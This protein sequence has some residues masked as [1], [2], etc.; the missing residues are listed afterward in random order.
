MD[1]HSRHSEAEAGC[2]LDEPHGL[3]ETHGLPHLHER[4]DLD[5]LVRGAPSAALL[6]GLDLLLAARDWR[7]T[8]MGAGTV[9][10]QVSIVHSWME[11]HRSGRA[12]ILIRVLEYE[13]LELSSLELGLVQD[14]LIVDWARSSLD[15]NMGT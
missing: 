2:R 3:L 15:S 12:D 10:G 5:G 9:G 14:H 11:R 7:L 4:L 1:S 6:L 8:L 13:G